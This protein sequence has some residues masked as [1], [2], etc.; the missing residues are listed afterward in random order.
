MGTGLVAVICLIGLLGG[1][2]RGITGFGGS[3]VMTPALSL[4]IEPKLVVPV[5][6]LLE[7]IAIIPMA[8]HAIKHAE[9]RVVL[10]ICTT[11]LLLAPF[12][13]FLLSNLDADV[14]RRIIAITVMIFASVLLAR[15]R[16]QLTRTFLASVAVGALAG[17]LL[18]ATGIGGPPIIIYMMLSL[19]SIDT[20][21]A[22]L[23]VYVSVGSI[24]ALLV[25]WYN[26]LFVINNEVS[27]FL[28]GISFYLGTMLGVK[29][30]KK[31]SEEQFRRITLTLLLCVAFV[32]FLHSFSL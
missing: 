4:F 3:M 25:Y 5:V 27:P 2:I 1:V 12:G 9:I 22:N 8:R 19:G 6:L 24:G 13:A 11:S 30:S 26:G 21:R 14:L 17:V 29:F 23:T 28:L 7:T 18:G 32:V 31:I 15:I 20:D 16:L 10:P